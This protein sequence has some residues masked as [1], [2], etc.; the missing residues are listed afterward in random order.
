MSPHAESV[1]SAAAGCVSSIGLGQMLGFVTVGSIATAI[2]LGAAG[3]LGGWLMKEAVQYLSKKIK[4][5]T[6]KE[7]NENNL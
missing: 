6:K 4:S 2:V 7:K 3:A 1:A 5:K